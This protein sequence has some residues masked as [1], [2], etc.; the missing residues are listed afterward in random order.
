MRTRWRSSAG[1]TLLEIII[2]MT[3]LGLVA[4]GIFLALVM[5]QR[6]TTAS[7]SRLVATEAAQETLEALRLNLGTA[8]L[9]AGT[10]TVALPTGSPLLRFGGTGEYTVRNGRFDP[11]TG[12]IQWGT[13]ADPDA[14]DASYDIKEVTVRVR[15]TPPPPPPP[16]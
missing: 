7:E 15:W 9:N 1:V 14:T 11:A 13:D 2:A 8:A 5:G 12:N 10:H 6:A 16:Q 3:I 4:G